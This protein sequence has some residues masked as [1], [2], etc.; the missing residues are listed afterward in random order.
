[1]TVFTHR[2]MGTVV[3]LDVRSPADD[4]QVAQAFEIFD[5][6]DAGFSPFR[7]DSELSRFGRGELEPAELSTDLREVLALGSAFERASGGAFSLH[8]AGALDANGVVKGWAAQ[9]AA[10]ALTAAGVGAFCLNAGGDLV[11]RGAPEA[12][13]RWQA[14]IRHPQQAD[15]LLGVVVLDDA[16]MATSGAYERG[17]HITDGRSGATASHWASVTVLDG[18]LTVADALATAVFAMGP[19]GPSWAY[20][21]FGASVVALDTASALTVVGPVEWATE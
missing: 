6:A 18:D 17:D 13:R 14:G 5:A 7:A 12:G 15:R 20:T 19:D 1:V 10:D 2:T 9:R 3:S 16:A 8:P 4:E 11:A 21:E